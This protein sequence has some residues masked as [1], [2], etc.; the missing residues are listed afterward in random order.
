MIDVHPL[1]DVLEHPEDVPLLPPLK[2]VRLDEDDEARL[3]PRVER[4][5]PD[6]DL[7]VRG[8]CCR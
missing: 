2:R 3:M 5:D 4:Y 6:H 8:I 7:E 1:Q